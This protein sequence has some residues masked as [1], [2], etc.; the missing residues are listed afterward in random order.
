MASMD[1]KNK[2][3]LWVCVSVYLCQRAHHMCAWFV[4]VCVVMLVCL[5]SWV[6]GHCIPPDFQGNHLGRLKW[7]SSRKGTSFKYAADD[8]G[9][10]LAGYTKSAEGGKPRSVT[11]GADALQ[12]YARFHEVGQLLG[13]LSHI[14]E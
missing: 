9:D 11:S 14:H 13:F 6:L 1:D 2:V 7:R 5:N 3:V 4:S 12:S 8:D 10:P